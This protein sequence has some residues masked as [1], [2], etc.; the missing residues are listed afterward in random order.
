MREVHEQLAA[1]VADAPRELEPFAATFAAR[2]RVAAVRVRDREHR[3]VRQQHADQ[4]VIARFLDALG[5]VLAR[6]HHAAAL[7]VRIAE[8]ARARARSRACDCACSA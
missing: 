6:R 1:Q 5:E 8:T 3:Q 7:I 2:V 4:V